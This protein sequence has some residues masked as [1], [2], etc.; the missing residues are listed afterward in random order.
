MG[1]FNIKYLSLLETNLLIC[2]SVFFVQCTV[3]TLYV[4]TI[5]L[6]NDNPGSDF[7][8]KIRNIFSNA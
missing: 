1:R 5:K 4:Y 7:R 3:S 6:M 8:Q 2:S